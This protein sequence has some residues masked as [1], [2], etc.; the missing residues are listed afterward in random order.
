[1][2]NAVP[3]KRAY[4]AAARTA[5]SARVRSRYPDR[6]PCIVER[7]RGAD[8]PEIDRQKF[9]VPTDL[10]MGQLAWVVRKRIQLPAEKALFLMVGTRLMPSCELVLN[11]YEGQKDADGFLYVTYSGENSFGGAAKSASACAGRSASRIRC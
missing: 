10:T 1:M 9:L 6:V 11:V 3:F 2:P 8:V 5:E 7:G 4:D